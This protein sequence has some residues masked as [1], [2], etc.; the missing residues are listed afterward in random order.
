[1]CYINVKDYNEANVHLEI[2]KKIDEEDE[3]VKDLERL[4]KDAKK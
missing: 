4:L 3:V 2:A 1:M